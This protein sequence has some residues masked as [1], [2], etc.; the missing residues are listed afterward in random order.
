MGRSRSKAK[1]KAK[2]HSRRNQQKAIRKLYRQRGGGAVSDLVKILLR[3]ALCNGLVLTVGGVAEADFSEVADNLTTAAASLQGAGGALMGGARAVGEG[4]YSAVGQLVLICVETVLKKGPVV[5]SNMWDACA[6]LLKATAALGS[7]GGGVTKLVIGGNGLAALQMLSK[8]I[9][10]QKA[11]AD[12][13]EP[14][15]AEIG[16]IIAIRTQL[17]AVARAAHLKDVA[18]D[19][20][21]VAI[22]RARAMPGNAIDM[23]MSVARRLIDMGTSI[24]SVLLRTGLWAGK[25][26]LDRATVVNNAIE[27]VG[28][29]FEPVD[30]ALSA[31][32][33]MVNRFM[34]DGF[35]ICAKGVGNAMCY[36][37]SLGGVALNILTA[38]PPGMVEAAVPEAVGAGAGA[39]AGLVELQGAFQEVVLEIDAPADA[40]AAAAP[41]DEGAGAPD[42]SQSQD[43]I[44][45]EM[46]GGPVM[47]LPVSDLKETASVVIPA[48][49]RAAGKG[50]P[51]SALDMLAAAASNAATERSVTP[52]GL[53]AAG[54]LGSL[55]QS[56]PYDSDDDSDDNSGRSGS[57]IS[58]KRSRSGKGDGSGAS[59]GRGHTKKYHK[60]HRKTRKHKKMKHNKT[61]KR[62]KKSKKR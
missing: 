32:S 9:E 2:K 21:A 12:R 36:A 14:T 10:G 26:G 41:M 56:H 53:A 16:K 61:H 24:A 25:A 7:A 43:S 42:G 45:P 33:D 50:R 40:A 57:P 27:N 11:K 4:A 59:G 52:A 60:K 29:A 23:G 17:Q 54:L 6:G 49:Q 35:S 55:S 48:A 15:D 46:Q 18:V 22:E 58:I 8:Y 39:G 47:M 34:V 30:V 28:N 31:A 13:G 38:V 3:I 51:P 62:H 5:G 44:S 37:R 1:A 20:G 19:N